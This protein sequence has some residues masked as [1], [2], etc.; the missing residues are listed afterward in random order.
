MVTGH[1]DLMHEPE[2]ASYHKSTRLVP[3]H[4]VESAF[5]Y[6]GTQLVFCP[7]QKVLSA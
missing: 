4:L 1:S 6:K 2:I 5:Y 3:A 7:S